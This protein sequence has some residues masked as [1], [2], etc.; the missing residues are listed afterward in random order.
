MIYFGLFT[1]LLFCTKLN[2]SLNFT[3]IGE[4]LLGLF[5][6]GVQVELDRARLPT[7]CRSCRSL[8]SKLDL[9]SLFVQLNSDRGGLFIASSGSRNSKF[10]AKSLCFFVVTALVCPSSA[11][12][13]SISSQLAVLA[14]IS[15]A[16]WNDTPHPFSC[17]YHLS[18][19]K[20]HHPFKQ[21]S[22]FVCWR[23]VLDHFN[24]SVTSLLFF[25]WHLRSS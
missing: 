15:S 25:P 17:G 22:F 4:H 19:R 16:V 18:L 8:R 13:C 24:C 23:L 3:S 1:V 10:N 12:A 5:E 6:T 14:L 11:A 2:F 20:H 9:K 7:K 21:M